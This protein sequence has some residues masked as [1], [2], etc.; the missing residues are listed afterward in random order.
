MMHVVYIADCK[1]YDFM[2]WYG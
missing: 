2:L 1:L